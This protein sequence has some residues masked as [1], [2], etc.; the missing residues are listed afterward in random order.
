[1]FGGKR[2]EKH[3]EHNC[4]SCAGGVLMRESQKVPLCLGSDLKLVKSLSAHKLYT[5]TFHSHD[6]TGL[7]IFTHNPTGTVWPSC[8]LG[9]SFVAAS[10]AQVSHLFCLRAGDKTLGMAARRRRRRKL[11]F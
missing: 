9:P 10:S 8:R 6:W 11:R 1:M 2:R 7:H 3:K 5:E 4:L